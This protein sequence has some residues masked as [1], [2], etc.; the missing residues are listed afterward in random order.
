M[1]ESESAAGVITTFYVLLLI[2]LFF[3]YYVKASK[4]QRAI[5]TPA[6]ARERLRKRQ[7]KCTDRQMTLEVSFIILVCLSE[8]SFPLVVRLEKGLDLCEAISY[9]KLVG[10]RIKFKVKS[11]RIFG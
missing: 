4:C 8:M 6:L 9:E 1:A 5:L 11:V 7:R 10:F 3:P 2:T